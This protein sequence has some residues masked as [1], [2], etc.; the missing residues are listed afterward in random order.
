MKKLIFNHH[1]QMAYFFDGKKMELVGKLHD[2][3]NLHNKVVFSI[4]ENIYVKEGEE[5]KILLENASFHSMFAKK[6]GLFALKN[7][8]EK[9]YF[10]C[11]GKT[12]RELTAE[13]KKEYF[14]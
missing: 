6:K 11:E 10:L 13:E 12:V 4:G 5:Y 7:H 1:N 3:V 8:Q 2:F 9:K 14:G